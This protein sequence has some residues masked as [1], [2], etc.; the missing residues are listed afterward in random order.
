MSASYP[1]IGD[2]ASIPNI[3]KR[4][5]KTFAKNIAAK[6]I[7][8]CEFAKMHENRLIRILKFINVI[9]ENANKTVKAD[10]ILKTYDN[11]KFQTDF[12]GLTKNALE[13]LFSCASWLSRQSDSFSV[14]R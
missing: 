10:K 7:R 14:E 2:L 13:K 8:T 1:Y 5:I 6:V 12:R 4:F 3:L 9:D 11:E